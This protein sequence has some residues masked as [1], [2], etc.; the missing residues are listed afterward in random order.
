M[1]HDISVTANVWQTINSVPCLDF[2]IDY[3]PI[4]LRISQT[5]GQF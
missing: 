1:T 2:F 5:F 3:G 4:F